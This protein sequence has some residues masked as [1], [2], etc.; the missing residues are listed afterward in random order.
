M[1]L[2]GSGEKSTLTLTRSFDSYKLNFNKNV[3]R[4]FISFSRDFKVVRR[5]F[6]RRKELHGGEAFCVDSLEK[7]SL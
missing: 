7:K 5:N 1:I 2:F 3:V 6:H 4:A